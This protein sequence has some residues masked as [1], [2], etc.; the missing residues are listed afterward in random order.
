MAACGL[1]LIKDASKLKF[2][3]TEIGFVPHAGSSYYLSRMPGEFGKFLSLTGAVMS[4]GD[5][6]ESGLAVGVHTEKDEFFNQIMS[7]ILL[8]EDPWKQP[9]DGLE[10]ARSHYLTMVE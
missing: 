1:P 10:V 6:I 4:A 8:Y 2:G 7:N 5:A 9:S 3:E